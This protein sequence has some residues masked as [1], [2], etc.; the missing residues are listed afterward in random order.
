MSTPTGSPP[1]VPEI[2]EATCATDGSGAVDRGTRLT[3][4][5]AQARRRAGGDVVVCGPDEGANWLLAK[6]IEDSISPAGQRPKAHGAHL[7]V[8]SLPHWQ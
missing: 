8:L 5:Q 7:G 4:A 1:P 3:L 2:Y 6:Q